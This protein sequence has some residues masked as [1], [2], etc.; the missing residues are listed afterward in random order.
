[1]NREEIQAWLKQKNIQKRIDS[2]AKKYAGKNIVIYSA[3]IMSCI[4]FE[5]YNMS[6][7]NIVGIADGKFDKETDFYGY[8][9][10]NSNKILE[11]KPDI[12]LIAAYKEK[13][14]KEYIIDNLLEEK[15]KIQIIP[16][17]KK[18]ILEKIRDFVEEED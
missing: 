13:E 5:D 6:K 18:S 9:A 16:I 11:L 12:I 7:L 10:V 1:M 3:G 14:I 4:L 17:V 2:L 8:K 15:S